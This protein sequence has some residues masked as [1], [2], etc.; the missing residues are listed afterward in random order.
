MSLATLKKK[1][2][3]TAYGRRA[4]TNTYQ[5]VT[6]IPMNSYGIHAG[7]TSMGLGLGPRV[8]YGQQSSSRASTCVQFPCSK[9]VPIVQKS[10][11]QLYKSRDI[12]TT[13]KPQNDA[14]SLYAEKKHIKTLK[15]ELNNCNSSVKINNCPVDS[16]STAY[17]RMKDKCPTTKTTGGCHVENIINHMK[18]KRVCYAEDPVV[19]TSNK[20]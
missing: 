4:N 8:A 5:A 17:V 12:C 9:K 3:I 6:G 13:V 1:T 14:A 18:S 7:N 19:K 15:C 16:K 10:Y 11:H 2:Q 20:C